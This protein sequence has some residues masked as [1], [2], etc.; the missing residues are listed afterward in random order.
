MKKQALQKAKESSLD[1]FS[2]KKNF[3]EGQ[4]IAKVLASSDIVPK[5]YRDNLPNC[6]VALNMAART[7]ADVMMVMQ[8]LDIIQGK[9]S[10]SSKFLI[11][12]LNTSGKFSPLRFRIESK[13]DISAISY[14]DYFWDAPTK[15]MKPVNKVFKGPVE[16]LTC[17]AYA[18]EFYTG[19][20]LTSPKITI[21]M[22]IRE[23]WYTKNGSKWQTIPELML[24][25]RAASF[26]SR[27]YAPEISM[28]MH[29]AEEVID[30]V[31]EDI[32]PKKKGVRKQKTEIK[33][34]Q[35][36]KTT[37]KGGQISMDMP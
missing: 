30:V 16:N 28:G 18:T 22:A 23:G 13:G 9:P 17:V 21:E 5:I 11:S 12:T 32:T 8:N 4:R 10:W 37:G 19:E 29:T 24:N 26:F 6:M 14:T 27:L 35:S 25:Y 34:R 7:G 3:E 33:D 15:K 2:N 31:Y 1:V 36:G 20:V